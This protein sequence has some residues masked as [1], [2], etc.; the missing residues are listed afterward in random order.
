MRI[1]FVSYHYW[2]PD[3]G[4]ELLISIERLRSLVAGDCEVTVLTSGRPGFARSQPDE[5]LEIRRSPVVHH[6]RPGRLVRR[7]VFFFWACWQLARSHFDVLHVGTSGAIGPL[8]HAFA[9]WSF[10]VLARLKGARSVVVHSLADSE[11]SAFD[12]RGWE[13]FWRQRY[14][15]AFDHIVAVSPALY[16][17]LLPHFPSKATLIPYGIRDDLFNRCCQATREAL[18]REKGV[19]DAAV[20][21]AFLGTVGRRKGFDLLAQ[22]FAE[23]AREHLNWYLWV[24]GPRTR[25]ENQNLDEREVAEVTQPLQSA[26]TRVTFWGRVDDRAQLSRIL[27][28][29]DVFVF[30]TRREGMGIAPIEAMAVG[31]PVIIARIPGVTDLANVEG[32]TGFY[33]PPG[34]LEALKAAMLRLGGGQRAAP[35]DGPARRRSR[36]GAICLERL[37]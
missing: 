10:C 11:T 2:P 16:H 15:A 36:A 3:F 29:S 12:G 32:E 4:G 14:F 25:V 34:D 31:L 37:H 27:S 22:A 20:V 13:G 23:L 9:A 26:G 17:A 19:G 18:R 6:T 5:G 8:S 35:E 21:F 7:F 1:A 30:P 24:I 33:V 28:A